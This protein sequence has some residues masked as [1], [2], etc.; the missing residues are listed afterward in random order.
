MSMNAQPTMAAAPIPVQTLSALSPVVVMPGL[1]WRLMELLV[2][3][4]YRQNAIKNGQ[5]LPSKQT[6]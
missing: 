1:D 5:M 4:R 6:R 2:S 3:V